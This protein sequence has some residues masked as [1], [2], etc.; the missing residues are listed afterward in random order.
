MQLSNFERTFYIMSITL[1]EYIFLYFE[2]YW[3][4]KMT[5]VKIAIKKEKLT[6]QI[7]EIINECGRDV[8]LLQERLF[9]L[10]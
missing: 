6:L 2:E 5:R 7:R 4:K 3:F 10:E 9:D 8:N 1:M